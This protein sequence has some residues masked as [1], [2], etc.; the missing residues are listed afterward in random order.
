LAAVIASNV[1]SFMLAFCS[2]ICLLKIKDWSE[3]TGRAHLHKLSF[4]VLCSRMAHLY[5]LSFAPF[6]GCAAKGSP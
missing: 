4:G 6:L 1:V 5:K 2:G 3:L